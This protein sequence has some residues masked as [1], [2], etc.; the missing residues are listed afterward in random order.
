MVLF[1]NGFFF[2]SNHL[3]PRLII[4]DCMDELS[5]FKFAPP[6]LTQAELHLLQNADVVFYWRA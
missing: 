2:F 1:A 3:N 4:Y 5:A 6:Q